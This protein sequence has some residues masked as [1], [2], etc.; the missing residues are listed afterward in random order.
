MEWA[1]V[2]VDEVTI[3]GSRCGPFDHAFKALA[4]ERIKVDPLV[5][6]RFDLRDGVAALER[7]AAPDVLEGPARRERQLNA[8]FTLHSADPR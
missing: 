8:P 6:A 5:S 3:V 1:P 4:E 2:V 7:A